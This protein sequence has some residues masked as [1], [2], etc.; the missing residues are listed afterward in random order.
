MKAKIIGFTQRDGQDWD[1][2]AITDKG[3]EILV[4]PFVSCSWKYENRE[5]LLNQWFEDDNAFQHESGVWLTDE[6]S[7]K[8][9]PTNPT[10]T[11]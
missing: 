5:H 8:L 6:Q 7:F 4:D 2:K 9:M 10:S 1:C 3:E 11:T